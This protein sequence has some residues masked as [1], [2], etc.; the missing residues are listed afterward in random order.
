MLVCKIKS[1]ALM[2]CVKVWELKRSRP[3]RNALFSTHR[4]SPV[5][6]F[7]GSAKN[8]SKRRSFRAKKSNGCAHVGSVCLDTDI[9]GGAELPGFE[10]WFSPL[11][12]CVALG[13]LPN[14]SV[15][16]SVW[17]VIKQYLPHRITPVPH[18][19]SLVPL[20]GTLSPDTAMI[21]SLTSFE[22]LWKFHLIQQ[23]LGGPHW[24]PSFFFFIVL[25]TSPC[26][27]SIYLLSSLI[28]NKATSLIKGTLFSSL[29]CLLCLKWGLALE[30]A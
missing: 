20:P 3:R 26:I 6:D 14:P 12:S 7:H 17:W 28:P 16:S 25:I 18:A 9:H 23:G 5:Q 13:K 8:R 22:S 29:M 27:M 10:S 19:S 2:S 4:V 1:K 15:P 21:S 30:S 24:Y 11:A